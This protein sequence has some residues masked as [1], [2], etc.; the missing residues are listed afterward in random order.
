MTSFDGMASKPAEEWQQTREYLLRELDIDDAVKAALVDRFLEANRESHR[1]DLESDLDAGYVIDHDNAIHSYLGDGCSGWD[2]LE[3]DYPDLKSLCRISMPAY[4]PVSSLV[5][6]YDELLFGLF[7]E[8]NGSG[9][10]SVLRPENNRFVTVGMV[11]IW[12]T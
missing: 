9:Q 10:V 4:D 8:G 2:G 1:L 7:G 5:M 11:L 3:L 12:M 6:I